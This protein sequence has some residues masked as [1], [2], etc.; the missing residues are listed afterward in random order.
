MN[1]LLHDLMAHVCTDDNLLLTSDGVVEVDKNRCLN[2]E[3][4]KIPAKL[5]PNFTSLLYRSENER[6]KRHNQK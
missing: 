6:P 5:H 3:V 2:S 4:R 1:Q